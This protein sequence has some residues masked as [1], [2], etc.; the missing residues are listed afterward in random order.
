MM[1]AVV[2]Q[3]SPTA[4]DLMVRIHFAGAELISAGTNAVAFT[5]LWCT[6]AAQALREQTLDKLSRAPD[7]WFK[8]KI[9][10]GAG[11]GAAQLRP[12]LDDLVKSEWILE[13]R[14]TT[15]GSPEYA[16]AI[17]LNDDRAQLWR[18]NLASVMQMWTGLSV[19]QNR[20]G[21]W[22]LKKH[23]PP[24]LLRFER[25]SDWVVI[26]CGQNELLLG[27]E[28][29]EPFL[30]TRIAVAG[31]SWLT[32]D[33]DWPRLARWFPSINPFDL[34]ETRWQV[35]GRDG[36][37]HLDGRLIFP[38]PLALTLE[39]WRLPTNTI[40]QPISSITAVRGIA[41]WLG[42]QK[43]AQPYEIS[44][45]PNQAFIWAQ[46]LMPLQTFAAVPVPEAAK[47]LAQ[48]DQKMSANTGWQSHFMEPITL[49]MTNNRISWRGVPFVAPNLQA[50]REPSGDFLI[51][52]FFP[53]GPKSNQPLPPELFQ[54]LGRTNLLYYHW[55]NTSLRLKQLPQLTQL[56][57]MLTRHRQLDAR[58]AAGKW[59]ASIEPTLG[60]SATEVTQSAP[61]QLTF[62]RQAAGG[63]TALE[64]IALANWLEAINFPG[65][66]LRQPPT[67]F[68]LLSPR[69]SGP[70]PAQTPGSSQP[71][72]LH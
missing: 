72:R 42:K 9:I 35:I 64:F 58:S 5:N 60:F 38:Q 70:S 37:L 40:C 14:D 26:D 51:G 31:T 2:T 22:E 62:S 66:D 68:S 12:L 29:L 43:W 46:A 39:K 1:A 52:E 69:I 21:N 20:P 6:P 63:L 10:A 24:N 4:P 55:E 33:L 44:P 7:V 56:G 34:P 61:D 50:V 28:I 11:D 53:S 48:L 18:T 17:R 16:L 41:P 71:F 49:V 25:H 47:A 57:L 45:V 36:N 15:N 59:L 27:N 54:E 3:A 67:E 8:S 32:A 19:A 13:V 23:L 30:K 65:C